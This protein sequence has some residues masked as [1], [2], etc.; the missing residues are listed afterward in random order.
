MSLGVKRHMRGKGLA[1]ALL[2]TSF[3]AFRDAGLTHTMIGVDEANPTAPSVSSRVFPLSPLSEGGTAR[4]KRG[5]GGFTPLDALT[6]FA[7]GGPPPHPARPWGVR[8]PRREGGSPP[9]T[10]SLRSLASVPPLRRGTTT[11][12]PVPSEGEGGSPPSTRSLRS[13]ASVPPLRRGT[14]AEPIRCPPFPKGG[15]HRSPPA[16]TTAEPGRRSAWFGT[17]EL[18]PSTSR[19]STTSSSP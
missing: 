14:T 15:P 16:Q 4:A 5:R 7:G 6:S 18:W 13:L 1:K 12:P 17:L 10:R 9:S 19:D 2:A 8:P 3:N 11:R